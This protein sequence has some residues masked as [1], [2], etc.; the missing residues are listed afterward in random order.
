MYWLPKRRQFEE[1]TLQLS[2]SRPAPRSSSSSS[3]PLG[4]AT[5]ALHVLASELGEQPE[6]RFVLHEALEGGAGA[7]LELHLTVRRLAD[8][9]SGPSPSPLPS[10]APSRLP[11]APSSSSSSAPPPSS[12]PV[13]VGP[14]RR[15]ASSSDELPSLAE[16]PLQSLETRPVPSSDAPRRSAA[17]P[18]ALSL[19]VPSSAPALAALAGREGSGYASSGGIPL[20]A[21]GHHE[22]SGSGAGNSGVSSSGAVS[23]SGTSGPSGGGGG[24]GG[25]HMRS[26][27]SLAGLQLPSVS[28]SSSGAG[29]LASPGLLQASPMSARPSG[30]AGLSGSVGGE[31]PE[32]EP[33]SS[34]SAK[35]AKKGLLGG[36]GHRRGKSHAV[37]PDEL[38]GLHATNSADFRQSPQLMQGSGGVSFASGPTNRKSNAAKLTSKLGFKQPRADRSSGS[39]SQTFSPRGGPNQSSSSLAP[40]DEFPRSGTHSDFL[41]ADTMSSSSSEFEEDA[42]ASS[43]SSSSSSATSRSSLHPGSPIALLRV[44]GSPGPGS[45][46]GSP[47]QQQQQ[48]NRLP[49][50][51]AAEHRDEIQF[52]QRQLADQGRRRDQSYILQHFVAFCQPMYT[53]GISV[54]AWILFRCLVEWDCF[55]NSEGR[56]F[57][58]QMLEGFEQ[59]SKNPMDQQHQLYW[60][61]SLLSLMVLL[62]SKLKPIPRSEVQR[63]NNLTV[64]QE[65]LRGLATALCSRAAVMSVAELRPLISPALLEHALLEDSA[66]TTPNKRPANGSGAST[67]ASVRPTVYSMIVVLE[68]L[69]QNLKEAF[70]LPSVAAQLMARVSHGMTAIA[71]NTLLDNNPRLCTFSN[72]L[73]MKKPIVELR[74]WMQRHQFEAAASMLAPLEEVVNVLCMNKSALVEPDVRKDVCPHL[75]SA[76]LG[77]LLLLYTPDSFDSE[78]VH[79]AILAALCGDNV[80]DFRVDPELRTPL[81]LDLTEASYEVNDL[82]PPKNV[83]DQP[84]LLFLCRPFSEDDGTSDAW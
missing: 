8:P 43:T 48:Q 77:Q 71:L 15:V 53:R 17:P 11:S 38:R 76:Q 19:A 4:R 69:R 26:P 35:T 2:L 13:S 59:L 1:K 25:G 21:R 29:S 14:S 37:T 73:Q 40:S 74:S 23:S 78:P 33:Q 51:V 7:E 52:Y 50:S 32:M 68:G 27:S 61:S 72:G 34:S 24:G 5:V 12:P 56:E 9:R 58:E 57:R 47:S 39:I 65:R 30:G 46:P 79:P 3:S 80:H 44:S 60:L 42:L 49:S 84:S 62:R 10:P 16:S 36:A 55:S 82:E 81:T 67:A 63:N 70:V 66:G 41:I 20:S 31:T 22:R 75:S 54:S 6:R 18:P 83:A 45:A 64:F 28:G